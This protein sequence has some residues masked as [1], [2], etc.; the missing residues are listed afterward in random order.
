M[1]GEMVK[2]I[3]V[4]KYKVPWFRKVNEQKKKKKKLKKEKQHLF[5][6]LYKKQEK[7]IWI[8]L[9][10]GATFKNSKLNNHK[11]KV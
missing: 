10:V 5:W 4:L 1:Q 11:N 6:L 3:T 8:F 2:D 9:G 7:E